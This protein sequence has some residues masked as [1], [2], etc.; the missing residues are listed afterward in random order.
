MLSKLRGSL[1]KRRDNLGLGTPHSRSRKREAQN[2]RT[3]E[4]AKMGTLGQLVQDENK[5]GQWKYKEGY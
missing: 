4:R 5:E 3:K 1:N 2:H